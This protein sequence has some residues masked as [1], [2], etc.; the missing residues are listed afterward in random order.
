MKRDIM[1][2]LAH[3]KDAPGRKPLLLTGVRQCGKTYILK[4]FGK[5]YFED[6]AYFNFDKSPSLG[7]IFEYD[8]DV[9]RIVEE[10]TIAR[11]GK[12]IILG[13]T[14]VILDE[15]QV[16]PK[17]I[18]SLKYFCEDLR[19]LHVVAAGSLLGVALRNENISYPVG[20]V[21]KLSMY[22]M[23]F[24]EFVMANGDEALL[25][26]MDR[27]DISREL[28]DMIAIPMKKYLK[29]YFVVGGMPEAVEKWI[30]TENLDAVE[31]VQ[32]SIL[33]D[34]PNDFGKHIPQGTDRNRMIMTLNQI[35]DS[36]PVQIAKENNKFIFSH[37]KKG[38]RAK[39]L[40]DAL[41]W[42][43]KSGLVYQLHLCETPEIPLSG[44]ADETY[45]KVFMA[46]IG[47]LRV[48]AGLPVD[49]VLNEGGDYIR[50]KGAMAEQFVMTELTTMG[51]PAFFWRSKSDAEV[52]FLT[53]YYSRITP[54]EVK[55]AENTKAKSLH[56]FCNRYHP[57]QAI[58][59]ST[60]NVGDNEDGTTH[61][62]SVPLYAISRVKEYLR[63][64]GRG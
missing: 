60:K 11:R 47:L 7:Q 54:I 27:M 12:P 40:E 64:D 55:S 38:A 2:K 13:A 9:Q 30:E 53:D 26:A 49:T 17:A 62:W 41:E 24:R 31:E 35:W 29:W 52:D 6:V 4:D 43:V 42:L 32:Q 57:A 3:W 51:I 48:K 22:P 39:D 63:S 59:L 56:T 34:Y 20:K 19:E 1:E 28:P 15:I 14:L 5:E 21:D 46:D 8:L 45:F 16:C 58:K 25:T 33:K 10:L 18:S 36:I 23:T 50:Y 37:V 61:V 44:M